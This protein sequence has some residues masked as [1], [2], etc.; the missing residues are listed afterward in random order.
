M[1]KPPP[2]I[3]NLFPTLVGPMDCWPEHTARAR[4][5]GFNWV[6]I[7]S[8]CE[9]GVSESLYSIKD[10][11]RINAKLVVA[12]ESD[13]TKRLRHTIDAIHEQG[14]HV[15]AD[16]VINHTAKDSPLIDHH[17]DWFRRDDKGYVISPAAIDPTDSRNVTV[18][19][20]LAE[21]D[22]A[23]SS[24]RQEL[25]AYWTA[26]VQ[27]FLDLGVDGFRCDAA[28]KVPTRLWQ[29]LIAAARRRQPNVV[30]AA[31]TLGC[32]LSEIRTLRDGGF[33]Y[34][35]NS[36]KWWNFDEPWCID[37]HTE[38]S[39]I[40][41]S[42]SFPESHDT[43]RMMT[44]SGQSPAVQNQRY[45]FAAAF[46]A[47][48]MMPIG[49]EYGFCK[50]LNTCDTSPADWEGEAHDFRHPI[51][52][53][54]RLKQSLPM[55]TEEGRWEIVGSLD[56]H[57]LTLLKHGSTEPM[58]LVINKHADQKQKVNLGPLLQQIEAPILHRFSGAGSRRGER[59]PSDHYQ[60]DAA[61]L[62]YIWPQA[63]TA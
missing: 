26:L 36:S 45:A 59:G 14:L 16:L 49:Y 18:W 10:H 60:L 42:I 35:F 47:G 21:V 23:N 56:E 9:P 55:L 17:P 46:S 1:P 52:E 57:V 58:G 29:Q 7:N 11:Y 2:I 41:P 34:L 22:N 39:A 48:V 28:Y 43:E 20:D 3:Y 53:I 12:G 31:E 15:M 40:A 63:A 24:K 27:Y 5:M 37:Q 62:M 8:F 30:F 50:R 51:G 4:E 61:E 33:D 25:W 32:R 6:F 38:F 44:E 19:R 13:P 54:N